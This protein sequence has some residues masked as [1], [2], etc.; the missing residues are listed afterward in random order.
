MEEYGGGGG[1][2]GGWG[3]GGGGWGGGGGLGGGGG[4]VGGVG[5][6]LWVWGGTRGHDSW[7]FKWDPGQRLKLQGDDMQGGH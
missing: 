4:V 3:L 6:G 7:R 5:V 1:G 2:G